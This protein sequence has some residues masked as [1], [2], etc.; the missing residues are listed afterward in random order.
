MTAEALGKLRPAFKKEGTVTAG[1]AS[2][3][4]DGAAAL[5]IADREFAEAH[6]LTPRARFVVHAVAAADPVVTVADEGVPISAPPPAGAAI[7]TTR[8]AA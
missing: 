3:L 2:T 5:L 1:N 4:S 7:S 6:G 8:A